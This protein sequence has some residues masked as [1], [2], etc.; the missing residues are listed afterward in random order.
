MQ[1]LAESFALAHSP[2][3]PARL[4]RSVGRPLALRSIT[5]TLALMHTP[6]LRCLTLTAHNPHSPHRIAPPHIPATGSPRPV[7]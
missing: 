2:F 7:L 6:L 4:A 5:L 1:T 3:L